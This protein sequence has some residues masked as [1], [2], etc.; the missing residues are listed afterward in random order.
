MPFVYILK[1]E[2]GK[3][4]VGSTIDLESRLK[5][6]SGGHT[7]STKRLGKMHLV[8]SQE[9]TSIKDARKVEPRLKRYKRKD[10]IEKIV[11]DKFIKYRP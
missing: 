8:F 5:H 7:P 2:I 3:Y 1:N 11:K 6:H 10:F 4:Y 9:Y